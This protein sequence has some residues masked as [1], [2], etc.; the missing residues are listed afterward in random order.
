MSPPVPM[1][2][3]APDE[4]HAFIEAHDTFMLDCDGVLWSGTNGLLPGILETLRWLKVTL[5]KRI[6]LM[7]NN[8]TKS[9]EAYHRK[10]V[11]LGIDFIPKVCLVWAWKN[12]TMPQ[13]NSF[14]IIIRRT[15]FVP[16]MLPHSS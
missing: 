16:R 3:D 5:G 6:F 7:T 12:D 4:I 2:L 11:A 15:S 10:I 13:Q 1:Q 9:R 8:S 14:T